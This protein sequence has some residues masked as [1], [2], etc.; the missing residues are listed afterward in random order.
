MAAAVLCVQ[1][2]S[3]HLSSTTVDRRSVLKVAAAGGAAVAS[4]LGGAGSVANAAT[5]QRGIANRLDAANLIIP[6]T[7][8]GSE[9]N[10]IDNTYYPLWLAGE[11]DVTQTLVAADTPLGLKYVGGPAGSEQIAAES[12]KEQRR[13]IGVPVQLRLRWV[14]TKFGVAEDRLFNARQRLNSFA[15]KSV[16]ASVE[17]SNVGGSN[18]AGVLAMGG[19]EDDPLQTTVVRFKGPAAQKTFLVAHGEEYVGESGNRFACFELLRSIFALTNQNTAPPVTTD[20]ET[21][22]EFEHINDDNIKARLRIASYLNAQSDLL[23]F[24][25]RNRAVSFADYN[26]DLKRVVIEQE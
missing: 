5:T 6:P 18:R 24:D 20:T 23:Y 10:G 1:S 13:Q 16:V 15:G 26:L 22:W 21:I 12:M 4:S 3:L 9:L 14:K 17:Y 19:T 25:A 8:M 2:Q 7:S 11:W